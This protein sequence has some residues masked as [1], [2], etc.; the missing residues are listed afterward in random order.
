MRGSERLL[1]LHGARTLK[2]HATE[3]HVKLAICRGKC[4]KMIKKRRASSCARE[5]WW[6]DELC[7]KVYFNMSSSAMHIN[8]LVRPSVSNNNRQRAIRIQGFV[9]SHLEGDSEA[10]P[11]TRLVSS[12]TLISPRPFISI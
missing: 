11:C 4:D 9:F 1:M 10:S 2:W 5:S 6:T 3:M 7:A 12:V 8:P